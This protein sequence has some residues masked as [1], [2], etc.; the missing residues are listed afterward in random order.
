M[1]RF[2]PWPSPPTSPIGLLVR[3]GSPT[4]A[5]T[6]RSGDQRNPPITESPG[7]ALSDDPHPLVIEGIPM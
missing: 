7:A 2:W 5:L 1:T 3:P 6:N 4:Q